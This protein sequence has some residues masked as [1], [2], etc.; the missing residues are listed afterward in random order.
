M[1]SPSVAARPALPAEHAHPTRAI[2]L[3]WFGA[4]CL[5][6]AVLYASAT[7]FQSYGAGRPSLV[8]LGTTLLDP[9]WHNIAEC[10]A[11]ALLIAAGLLFPQWRVGAV[12]RL[13]RAF[14]RFA[15]HRTRAILL[16]GSLPLIVRLA[17]IPVLGVPAPLVAD[18]FGYLL[19]ADTFAS[20]RL[21]NPT[22]PFWK[23]FETVY[24]FHQPS[25]TSIYPVAPA[26]IPAIAKLLGMHPW[27]GV[28][29]CAGLLCALTCWMLQ[30]W[31]PPKWALI[32]SL[33]AVCRFTIVSS[34]MNTYWGGAAAAIGGALVLGALPRI[35]KY[36]RRR[37]ALLFALGL[38]VLAQ[39]RPF[40]GMLFALAP[41]G[42]LGWWLLREKR[43][44][45]RVRVTRVALPLA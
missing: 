43:V 41:V 3:W 38:A 33:L 10:M 12:V 39:S 32:G 15:N 5:L 40:E 31:L 6:F 9:W 22:H 45:P 21:A 13:E 18:E 4:A 35:M 20:G 44:A 37:D 28:C 26:I 27:I 42:I 34:W 8:A 11:A 25:Y 24:V 17:I 2:Y 1:A 14:T 19:L 23:H 7:L 16:V 36:Q 29:F 30:G